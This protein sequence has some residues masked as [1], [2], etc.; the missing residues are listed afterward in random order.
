MRYRRRAGHPV[1]GFAL[2]AANFFN[3]DRTYGMYAGVIVF[4][5]VVVA[6]ELRTLLGAEFDAELE[7][8]RQLQAGIEAE[9]ISQLRP[10]LRARPRRPRSRHRRMSRLGRRIRLSHQ[11]DDDH[12]EYGGDGVG[13]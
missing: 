3:Y 9:E 8:G 11:D 13:V 7:R 12:D 4:L 1:G 5:L 6:S 2:Y 10:A